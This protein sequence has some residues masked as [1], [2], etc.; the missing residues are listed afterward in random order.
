ML[1]FF[2]GVF[3]ICGVPKP[4]FEE[5]FEPLFFGGVFFYF[6]NAEACF[7]I[8]GWSP[9]SFWGVFLILETPKPLFHQRLEP[10]LFLG[11]CF[12]F[13]KLRSLIFVGGTNNLSFC[14]VFFKG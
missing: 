6:L 11:V 8:R 14:F 13:L 9:F 7:F 2:E 4:P 10:L 3:I 5:Q 12:L 1:D